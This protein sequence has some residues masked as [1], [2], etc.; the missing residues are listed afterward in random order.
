VAFD[1]GILESSDQ[2]KDNKIGIKIVR[3]LKFLRRNLT[4]SQLKKLWELILPGSV[5]PQFIK[6]E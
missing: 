6:A 3:H 5:A 1:L 2:V 4:V